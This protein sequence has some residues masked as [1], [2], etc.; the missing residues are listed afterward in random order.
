MSDKISILPEQCRGARAVLGWSRDELATKA[1]VSNAT[2]ADFEAGKRKPYD[3]TLADIQ[4]TLEDA[5]I[6]F[7]PENGAGPG[8]RLA[9]RSDESGID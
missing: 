8:V 4:K 7:I 9:R 5:G 6:I 1:R 3:R 2:L